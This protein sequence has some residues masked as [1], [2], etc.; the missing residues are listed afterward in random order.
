MNQFVNKSHD[1]KYFTTI[2]NIVDDMKLSPAAFR[3]YAHIKRVAGENGK[4]WQSTRTLA[5][6]CRVSAG[7][8]SKA[9]KE[10]VNAKLITIQE[11]DNDRGGRAYHIITIVDIWPTNMERYS[12]SQDEHAS[13]NSEITSSPGELKKNPLR[14]TQEEIGC[15]ASAPARTR[16]ST[17]KKKK[18]DP[19]LDH[20][21]IQGYREIARLHVPIAWRDD[22]ITACGD[23]PDA[24]ETWAANPEKVEDWKGVVKSWV[25]RQYK[26]G[27]VEG[28][29]DVLQNGWARNNQQGTP[30]QARRRS[31]PQDEYQVFQE[32]NQ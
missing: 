4:C 3:L 22:V 18:R 19:R 31:Y 30:S 32:L 23:N 2:P 6:A 12:S 28:M 7:S 27:N 29:L 15:G 17:T 26:P 20:P 10:L 13:S 16:T 11:K 8:I 24:P 1:R 5:N 25:G 9:K 21:A 14:K